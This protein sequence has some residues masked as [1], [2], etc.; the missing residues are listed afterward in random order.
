MI[1]AVARQKNFYYDINIKYVLEEQI[2]M[3]VSWDK[4]VLV[5]GWHFWP[6]NLTPA[7]K[8]LKL[9]PLSPILCTVINFQFV[10]L[11]MS[12]LHLGDTGCHSQSTCFDLVEIENL[13]KETIGMTQKKM[14]QPGTRRHKK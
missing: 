13:T 4:T 1:W 5:L 10:L 2:V 6:I 8:L 3:M 9:A 14:V 12:R 7:G 11:A